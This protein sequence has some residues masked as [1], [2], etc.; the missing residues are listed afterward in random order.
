MCSIHMHGMAHQEI[1]VHEA[2]S[3][4]LSVPSPEQ[5]LKGERGRGGPFWLPDLSPCTAK[6]SV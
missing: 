2:A 3:W 4:K 6:P 5:Q 1:W